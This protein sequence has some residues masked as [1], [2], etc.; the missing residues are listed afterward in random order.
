MKQIIKLNK[1]TS[2][3]IINQLV[4]LYINCFAE[5]PWYELFIQE[6][7]NANFWEILIL[8]NN[9]ILA[10]TD[11]YDQIIGATIYFPLCN[12]NEVLDVVGKKYKSAIYCAELFV[13]KDKRK[14]GVASALV[15]EAHEIAIEMGYKQVILRTSI[16]LNDRK[17]S[18]DLHKPFIEIQ[19][20][21]EKSKRQKSWLELRKNNP[22]KDSRCFDELFL[23]WL[24]GLDSNQRP[25]D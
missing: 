17:L 20:G 22:T 14:H 15:G 1:N 24:P 3:E 6:E 2:K 9:I 21:V 19:K 5:P 8:K 11:H 25:I 7:V 12:K 4:K 10:A 16:I 18:L 23:V 13:H